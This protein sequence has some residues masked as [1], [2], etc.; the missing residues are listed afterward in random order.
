MYE[1]RNKFGLCPSCHV[2]GVYEYDGPRRKDDANY[3]EI[4]EI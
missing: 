2:T 3:L 1:F 4:E